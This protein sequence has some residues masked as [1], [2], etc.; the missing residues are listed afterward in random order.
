MNSFNTRDYRTVL[1]SA[2]G[3]KTIVP[4]FFFLFLAHLL[5][6]RAGP[7]VRQ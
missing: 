7:M 4:I 1:S 5:T 2:T 3:E 6:G